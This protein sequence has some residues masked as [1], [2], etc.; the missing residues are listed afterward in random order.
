MRQEVIA[1]INASINDCLS[2]C[3]ECE[4]PLSCLTT[5][6]ARLRSLPDWNE[7][8]IRY[9]EIAVLKLLSMVVHCTR[10]QPNLDTE[11]FALN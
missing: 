10:E 5:Y 8:E 9:V 2:R 1:R 3:Y 6:L 4:R 11:P 7:R